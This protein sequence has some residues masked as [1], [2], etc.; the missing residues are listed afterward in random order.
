MK[1]IQTIVITF[2]EKVI[3][4]TWSDGTFTIYTEADK[5]KYLSDTKREQDIL[6]VGWV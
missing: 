5:T 2:T 1:E 3:V 4:V 6:A